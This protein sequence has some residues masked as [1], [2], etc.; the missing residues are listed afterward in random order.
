MRVERSILLACGQF[1][2]FN[3]AL[4]WLLAARE[5]PELDGAVKVKTSIEQFWSHEGEPY[6]PATYTWTAAIHGS[7]MEQRS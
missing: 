4:A 1:A 5:D 7:K 3:E 2:N 6:D